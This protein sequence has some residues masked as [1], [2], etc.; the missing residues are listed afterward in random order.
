MGGQ[1]PSFSGYYDRPIYRILFRWID[2][3]KV[4]VIRRV[5]ATLPDAAVLIDIGCGSGGILRRVARPGDLAVAAEADPLLLGHARARGLIGVRADFEAPLP[6]AD[7]TVD[8]ALMIDAIEHAVEPRRVLFELHRVLRPGGVAVVF[9]PPYD[10]VRWLLA[11]R[12][13]HLVTRRPADHISPFTEESLSWVITRRFGRCQLGRVNG[14]LS[15]YA[16]ARKADRPA[17]RETV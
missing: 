15:M 7:E 6:F 16:I 2:H 9:T 14:N 12:F 3:R 10:S 13:H 17:R 4:H 1:R 5:L 11:E 8:L